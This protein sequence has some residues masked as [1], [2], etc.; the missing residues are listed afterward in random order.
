M[1][2]V[3]PVLT[4]EDRAMFERLAARVVELRLETPALLAIESAR[5]LSLVAGQALVFFQPFL[6]ALF[7]LP[8][9]ERF[10]RLIEGRENLELLARLI[11]DAADRRASSAR[12]GR[13]SG[14]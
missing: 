4:P 5:P 2:S 11:E 14:S 10:A 12:A 6:E 13:P 7:P 1:G 9:L 8:H 3:T